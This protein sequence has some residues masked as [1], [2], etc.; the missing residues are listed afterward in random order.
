M[1]SVET[2]ADVLARWGATEEWRPITEWPSYQVSS[3]GRMRGPRAILAPASVAGYHVVSLVREREIKNRRVHQ[4]VVEAF[5]GPAPFDAAIIAHN[6]GVRGNNRVT[7]LRWASAVENQRDRV[8]HGTHS[9]G[10][11]IKHAKLTGADI[12]VI[13]S[14]ANAGELYADI[15]ADFGVSVSTVSLIKKRADVAAC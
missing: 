14:R 8:R 13:R 7:N 4:L 5:V 1:T 15:A 9:R 12:P 10:S 6:D 11:D 3:F 2:V